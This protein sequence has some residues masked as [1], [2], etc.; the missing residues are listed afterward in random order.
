MK[1][2]IALTSLLLG[3]L[4]F[5]SAQNKATPVFISGTDGYKSFRIPAI[6]SLKNGSL[7]AFAEGRVNGSGDFGDVNI[8]MKRS[9]DKGKTWSATQT[10]VD[11]NALQAGNPAP[12][13]DMA[14]PAYPNGRIFLFYNTGNNHEGEVRKGKGLREVWYIT[15]VDGGATW[16]NSVNITTQV[17]RPKQFQINSAY[18][19]PDDWR[20]Y[21]NTPGH[22][23]QLNKG[24]N[25]GR[26]YVIGNHSAGN[27]Q[28]RFTDY[29]VHGFYTDD[30][31]KTFHLSENL[32][33]P[34]SNEVMAAEL[35]DGK[36]MINA[37][38]QKGDIRCRIVAV[39]KSGGQKWDTVYYDHR[40]ADPVCQGSILSVQLKKDKYILLVCNDNDENR[41]D[42]LTLRVSIDDGKNWM[43]EF[44]IDKSAESYKGDFTAYSDLVQLNKNEIGVLY[45]FDGYKQIVF[46]IVNI[47]R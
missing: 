9:S 38:N 14:D 37:R 16:S 31:G 44:V 15:S 10:I 26:M 41:R 36:L 23:I 33:V 35:S 29:D 5:V 25:K 42:N 47:S 34:G 30:H 45:E 32:A 39:S 43:K 27:P 1:K 8:V 46:K 24:I 40:L 21:A 3:C 18:N 22:A 19:F 4:H 2:I 20:S 12:V 11:F 28:E 7:L 13:V 6:I 17:H